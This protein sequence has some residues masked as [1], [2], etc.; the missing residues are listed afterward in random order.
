MGA[1][2]PE[3]GKKTLF[4][5]NPWGIAFTNQRG[6]EP[7]TPLR[8]AAISW[9]RS[10][11]AADGTLSFTGGP[12]TTRYIDLND[13]A[14]PATS[15][16]NAGKNPQGI[17]IT[18]D[19][20]RPMANFVSRNISNVNLV[21]DKVIQVIRTTA[22]PAPGSKQEFSLVGAE[23]FFPREAISMSHRYNDFGG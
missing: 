12:E 7:V 17:V 11:C 13:P 4:F 18:D 14:D 22:L 8:Q 5:A 6:T 19:G 21:T 1:Q 15:G 3:A 10:I 16:D 23:M 9:S 2:T 20:R